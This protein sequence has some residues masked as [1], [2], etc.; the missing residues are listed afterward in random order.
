M[1]DK[2]RLIKDHN[3][4]LMEELKRKQKAKKVYNSSSPT[5]PDSRQSQSKKKEE[6]DMG[7]VPHLIKTQPSSFS[8]TSGS[9]LQRMIAGRMG[10]TGKS[11]RELNNILNKCCVLQNPKSFE[12]QPI[13]ASRGL[14]RGNSFGIGASPPQEP[15]L[16]TRM[17][18]PAD[19]NIGLKGS[20][21]T[22]PNKS[23]PRN[24]LIRGIRSSSIG[25]REAQQ[26]KTN[27]GSSSKTGK[28]NFS[29]MAQGNTI[30]AQF[31]AEKKAKFSLKNM[32]TFGFSKKTSNER[33]DDDIFFCGCNHEKHFKHVPKDF[34]PGCARS[35]DWLRNK[36][37]PIVAHAELKA[38]FE[39]RMNDG[40]ASS[41]IKEH[42]QKDV[43]RTF[44]AHKYL[45]QDKVRVRLD[46]LLECI[47]LIYPQ[48]GYVQGMNFIAA[49]LLYHCDEY[50][51]LGVVKILFEQLELKDMFLP[52]K[53]ALT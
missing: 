44:S 31:E 3:T 35:A 26:P 42:I 36:Y 11:S 50:C 15:E 12:I 32:L 24:N 23:S 10:N 17:S 20:P 46:R 30:M 9:P 28:A 39:A 40:K 7:F 8:P 37:M 38:S 6:I 18:T 14:R 13:V 19:M 52:S 43:V 45:S 53:L 22:V 34:V 29:Q 4:Q 2:Q 49:T 25:K 51:S 27:Y 48:V 47:A 21:W 41:T 33:R 5:R 1:A 16:A